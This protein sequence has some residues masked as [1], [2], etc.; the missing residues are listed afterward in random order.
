MIVSGSWKD[1]PTDVL[2]KKKKLHL[3]FLMEHE[4]EQ[5]LKE[6]Q[7]SYPKGNYC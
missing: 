2:H 4:G 5:F 6:K 1:E 3:S 7:S